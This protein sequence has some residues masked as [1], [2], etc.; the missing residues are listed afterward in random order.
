MPETSCLHI[1]NR[2]SDPI[3]VVAM[4]GGSVRIGRAAY[5]D[6][7][8]AD[9][10]LDDEVCRLRRRHETW[11]LV[12]V[13][14]NGSVWLDGRKVESPITLKIGQ[15][16]LV[17]THRFTLQTSATHSPWADRPV[18]VPEPAPLVEPAGTLAAERT[19]PASPNERWMHARR[20]TKRW[21]SRWRAAGEKLRATAAPPPPTP[22]VTPAPPDVPR[23]EPPDRGAWGR[24]EVRVARPA[25]SPSA[26]AVLTSSPASYVSPTAPASKRRP[27]T[28]STWTDP[29]APKRPISQET[30][31]TIRPEPLFEPQ[32]DHSARPEEAVSPDLVGSAEPTEQLTHSEPDVGQSAD[33]EERTGDTI[34]NRIEEV[35]AETEFLALPGPLTLAHPAPDV[36]IASDPDSCRVRCA[37]QLSEGSATDGPHSGPYETD[38]DTPTDDPAASGSDSRPLLGMPIYEVED[39]EQVLAEATRNAN[40]PTPVPDPSPA[41]VKKTE[42]IP[43]D[44]GS[45]I[46]R[47]QS[48][49]LRGASVAPAEPLS[50]P[51]PLP[52]SI[53]RHD[54]DDDEDVERDEPATARPIL[55]SARRMTRVERPA[56]EPQPESEP[57]PVWERVETETPIRTEPDR[58]RVGPTR[59]V[60]HRAGEVSEPEEVE[61]EREVTAPV[62]V[63]VD[64][65]VASAADW[66]YQTPFVTDTNRLEPDDDLA[67]AGVA[68]GSD[69]RGDRGRDHE[70][71]G[72]RRDS[73]GPKGSR[74]ARDWPTVGDILAAQ[75]VRPTVEVAEA[76]A[77]HPEPTVVREPDRWRLPLWLAW[78]PGSMLAMGVGVLG[79]TAAGRWAQDGYNTGLV[80]Q[81]MASSEPAKTP[82][83]AEVAPSDG[84]WITTSAGHLVQWAAYLDRDTDNPEQAREARTLLNRAAMISPLNPTVRYALARPLT[85]EE[86]TPAF[87]LSRSLGQSRDV[88]ALAWAG[89]TLLAA[90]K[91]DAAL[92]AFRAALEMAVR[93]DLARLGVP[94]FLDDP[95]VRRYALPTE[96]LIAGV[97]REMASSTTWSYKDWAETLPRG[98]AAAT[99]AARVLRESGSPDAAVALDAALAEAG[100][101]RTALTPGSLATAEARQ[102]EAVRLAAAAEALT[103]KQ[104]WAEARDRYLEAVEL[105]PVEL[106]RRAWWLNLADLSARLGDDPERQKALEA[107]K[108]A[109]LKDDVTRRAVELQRASGVV[110]RRTVSRVAGATTDETETEARR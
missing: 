56:P 77:R 66:S 44:L 96:D 32:R 73:P 8:L 80:A 50:P 34:L 70:A 46:R 60:A 75:G 36:L 51:A 92:R 83:P 99:V 89:R 78:L 79:L 61:S 93:A 31:R 41:P 101:S 55:G 18:P 33:L 100:S 52:V 94:D 19:S 63:D 21:E 97:V 26:S 69:R 104:R 14:R 15:T 4:T 85:G 76:R 39:F 45:L 3:R 9:A 10:A 22:T 25:V 109:D 106:I 95:Q 42:L 37:D 88:P 38:P 59:W 72:L 91:R 7:R 28:S 2:D 107:A 1:Q 58:F 16:F 47:L 13:A 108:V 12:P 23:A 105:M 64:L 81:R 54:D 74:S 87:Q 20:E 65:D 71:E 53:D 35:A 90:G 27:V 102:A 43:I 40:E 24:A 48:L 30:V 68:S 11:Q 5:C 57:E 6:V 84:S 29:A 82:L 98:T 86:V 110:T 49:I 67:A 17:G 103:M 62:D